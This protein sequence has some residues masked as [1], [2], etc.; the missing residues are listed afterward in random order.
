MQKPYFNSLYNIFYNNVE[1]YNDNNDFNFKIKMKKKFDKVFILYL[2]F[3]IIFISILY[4][5]ELI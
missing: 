5:F 1:Q 2:T 3:I 4:F